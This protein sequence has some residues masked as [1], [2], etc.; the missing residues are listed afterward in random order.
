MWNLRTMVGDIVG[1]GQRRK[2]R[3]L[4]IHMNIILYPGFVDNIIRL[5]SINN[6]KKI[7]F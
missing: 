5:K 6:I 7:Y 2:R 4:I 3:L 1:R